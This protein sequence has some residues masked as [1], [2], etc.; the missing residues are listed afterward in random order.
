MDLIEILAWFPIA[1]A[2]VQALGSLAG[3][4]M[5]ASGAAASNAANLQQQQVANAQMLAAQQAQH[6][7]NTAFM[8]DQQHFNR[9]ERQYGENFNASQAE[10]N[11]AFASH[12]AEVNRNFQERMSNTAY[13]RAMADMKAAGLN[14][15]L[16]YGQGGASTAAGGQASG[17]AATSPGAS[18]G[19]ASSAGGPGLGV[20]NQQ[21][22]QEEMG[23]AVGRIA[24]SA[25]DAYKNSEASQ[26]IHQQKETEEN[27]TTEMDHRAKLRGQEVSN[28]ATMGHNLQQ[29]WQIKER[30]KHLIE[31]QT[32]AAT[33]TSAQT[34][35]S[36]AKLLEETRQFKQQ[37]MP[38]YGLGERVLRNLETIPGPQWPH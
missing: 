11:R 2:G 16:A 17:S 30:Q 36:A 33:A 3:G 20:A 22:T 7:Q 12:E 37:G 29:D 35:A 9:E 8:E 15:I 6:G 4:F 14:P 26:L 21:N 38:G 10:I 31:E 24:S 25:V 18:S 1:A 5:S 27:A 32:K 34:Y 23:R 19:A 28:A 13:Q